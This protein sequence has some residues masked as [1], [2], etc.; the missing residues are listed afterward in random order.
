M[1]FSIDFILGRCGK[2]NETSSKMKQTTMENHTVQWMTNNNE[3]G[4]Y[5]EKNYN[6][7]LPLFDDS[8]KIFNIGQPP[9]S[10]ELSGCFCN[11]YN[12]ALQ[13]LTPCHL[14]EIYSNCTSMKQLCRFVAETPAKFDEMNKQRQASKKMYSF[15]KEK[16][17]IKDSKINYKQCKILNL[18]VYGEN[19]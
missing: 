7:F 13:P 1:N 11:L 12:E 15:A 17:N 5:P 6:N 18:Q 14:N 19:E 16:Q 3:L 8:S 10:S 9:T 4:Q 2:K